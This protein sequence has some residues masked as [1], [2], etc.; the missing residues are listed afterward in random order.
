MKVKYG[1]IAFFIS[2]AMKMAF[3]RMAS[4]AILTS[5]SSSA[6]TAEVVSKLMHDVETNPGPNCSGV[7]CFL[8]VLLIS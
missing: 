5:F 2:K 4:S 6:R 7:S 3:V 1:N 8:K